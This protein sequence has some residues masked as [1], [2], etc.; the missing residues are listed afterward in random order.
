LRK[1]RGA[2]GVEPH[3]L[4]RALGSAPRTGAVRRRRCFLLEPPDGGALHRPSCGHSDQL[5]GP[6]GRPAI[7][8]AAPCGARH[9]SVI[10]S[11]PVSPL[12]STSD[13]LRVPATGLGASAAE[14]KQRRS[15]FV[16]E[17]CERRFAFELAGSADRQG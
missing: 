16:A 12:A 8:A 14:R 13:C 6:A 7:L 2:R 15:L 3:P 17:T 11:N 10:L 9:M 5:R 4:S 1:R